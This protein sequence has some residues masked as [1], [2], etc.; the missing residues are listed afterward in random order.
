MKGGLSLWHAR[1]GQP[2]VDVQK[3]GLKHCNIP[4]TNEGFFYL[5]SSCCLGK[6]HRLPPHLSTTTYSN[7]LELVYSGLWGAAPVV[8]STGFSYCMSFVD[9]FTRFTWIFLLTTKSKALTIFQQFK[10]MVENQFPF[11][12]KTVQSDWGGKFR[13]VTQILT[14]NGISHRLICSHTPPKMVW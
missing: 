3:H 9:T 1:L 7:P 2:G 13:P 14:K 12:I 10:V 4:F 8:S 6:T 5:C 11:K